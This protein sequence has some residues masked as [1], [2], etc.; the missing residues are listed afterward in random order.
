VAGYFTEYSGMKFAFF[1]MGEYANMMVV[2]SLTTVLFFGGWYPP[3]PHLAI[4]QSLPPLPILWF[5][6]KV[7][8]FVFLYIWF[9]ATFPRYR[10]DQLMGLMWKWMLP[11]ALVNLILLA[12]VK[13]WL[14]R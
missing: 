8:F 3:F 5:F 2:A 4:W 1:Y 10:F 6:L 12:L 7:M 11:L 9:R 14:V 13:L